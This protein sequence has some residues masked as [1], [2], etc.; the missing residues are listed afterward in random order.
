MYIMLW[1]IPLLRD[2]ALQP[3]KNNKYE[4]KSD[5]QAVTEPERYKMDLVWEY[6][7]LYKSFNTKTKVLGGLQKM[8]VVDA[9]EKYQSNQYIF[10]YN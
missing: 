3:V 8:L 2:M 5:D 6:K 7:I 4:G 1:E 10:P 9:F